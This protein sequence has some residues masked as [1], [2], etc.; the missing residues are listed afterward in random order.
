MYDNTNILMYT[1][2]IYLRIHTPKKTPVRNSDL[3]RIWVFFLHK[4]ISKKMCTSH[5]CDLWCACM[6]DLSVP[7]GLY[8]WPV[9]V[10]VIS[11]HL[12]TSTQRIHE[13]FS[14][15][16]WHMIYIYTYIYILHTSTQRIHELLCGLH[17][18]T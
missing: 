11:Y 14:L 7:I 16:N 17:V 10:H 6:C 4:F 5:V 9:R 15:C 13:L 18:F 1:A 8:V 12:H 2:H 3:L